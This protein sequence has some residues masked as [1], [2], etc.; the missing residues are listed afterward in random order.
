MRDYSDI[1]NAYR[2]VS[3][4]ADKLY[5]FVL[6]YHNYICATHTYEYENCSMMAIHTLTYIDDNPGITATELSKLWHKS[7][8]AISQTIKQLMDSE[9][10][11][12]RYLENNEKTARLYV[13]EKGKRLSSVH[14]AYDVAD[15]LQTTTYLVERCGEEDLNAFYRIIEKYIELLKGET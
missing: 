14:K 10:I 1:D 15:I 8:S 9:Y 4:R 2:K 6:L 3:A 7:K 11:E 13:T 12:K 5:E